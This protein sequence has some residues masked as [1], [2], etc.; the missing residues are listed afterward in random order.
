MTF[1]NRSFLVL[2]LV[3]T[4]L[5]SSPVCATDLSDILK[6]SADRLVVVREP[7][8]VGEDTTVPKGRHLRVEPGGI[9]K[10]AAGVT[11]TIDGG[12]EAGAYQIFSGD[13]N[14]AGDAKIE[15]VLPEWFFDG[16]YDDEASDW[17]DAINKSINFAANNCLTVFLGPQVYNVNSTVDLTS[18]PQRQRAGMKL[19]GAL[20]STQYERGTA[21]LGN[22]G[23]GNPI[24]ETTDTDGIHVV[25]L[26]LR[27]GKKNPS[28]IGLL[29]ARGTGTGWGG[30]H[31]YDNLYV[32]MGS[33]PAAN[34]GVGTIGVVNLAGEET[35]YENLQVWANLPVVLTWDRTFMVTNPELNGTSRHL[36]VK[37]P[38]GLP[39]AE[40]ASSTVYAFTGLGRLIALDHISPV[41][42]MNAAGTVDMGHTFMQRRDADPAAG[43]VGDYVAAIES[44]NCY[45][46]RHF[47]SLEGLPV[48]ML[49]RRDLTEAEIH[50]RIA[51]AE[52]KGRPLIQLYDDG[53]PYIFRNVNMVYYTYDTDRPLID[54]KRFNEAGGFKIESSSFR[55]NL[56]EINNVEVKP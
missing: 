33:V 26:A 10:I 43:R 19:M 3:T 14:V 24:L 51:G 49:S 11:L 52:A 48:Y 23:P 15:R 21:L 56:K 20:R 46:F 32:N 9:I 5:A 42:L 35:R 29:Q 12:L 36:T 47:G 40:K 25:N 31:V 44:W 2:P 16:N 39:L 8:A 6:T 41:L 4:L 1:L 50:V 38:A 27:A 13:G 55:G 30:D 54:Y 53:G 22:T 37:S 34:D 45:Q 17:S 18:T 28:T 7:I